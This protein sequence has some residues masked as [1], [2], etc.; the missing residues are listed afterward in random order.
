MA[1]VQIVPVVVIVM[2]V[3]RAGVG[4]MLVQFFVMIVKGRVGRWFV[5]A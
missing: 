3:V 1:L 5:R 2:L 4:V